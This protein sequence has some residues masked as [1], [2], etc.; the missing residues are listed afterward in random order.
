VPPLGVGVTVRDFGLLPQA[1]HSANAATANAVLR[2]PRGMQISASAPRHKGSIQRIPKTLEAAGAVVVTVT[3]SLLFT[4]QV[5][6]GIAHV[7]FT[8]TAPE[9][10]TG[11]I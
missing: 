5:P 4:V 3:V 10:P 2:F 6:S 11:A 1:P 7:A 8:L 9:K